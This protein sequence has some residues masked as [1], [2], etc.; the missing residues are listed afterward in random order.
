[1][2]PR[3]APLISRQDAQE[4]ASTIPLSAAKA[5]TGRS[6]APTRLIQIDNRKNLLHMKIHLEELTT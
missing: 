4:R 5:N 6:A 3:L 1:M 2:E